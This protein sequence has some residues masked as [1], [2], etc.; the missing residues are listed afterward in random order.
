MQ[1]R[2]QPLLEILHERVR[3][4]ALTTLE[5]G[6]RNQVCLRLA[7]TLEAVPEPDLETLA[8]LFAAA[9][10]P[11]RAAPYAERAGDWASTALAFAQAVNLYMVALDGAGRDNRLRVLEK[12][13]DALAHAG[14]GRDAAFVYVEAARLRDDDQGSLLRERA[15]I[16]LLRAGHIEAG[17]DVLR[18]VA[19]ALGLALPPSP[20]RALA[21]LVWY[22]T[23]IKLRRQIMRARRSEA[24]VPPRQLRRIDLCWALG[25]GLV[26]VDLVRA[27]GYQSRHVLLASEAGEPYRISCALAKEAILS[28]LENQAGIV[29]AGALLAQAEVLAREVGHPHAL[30]WATTA[31]AVKAWAECRLAA[32]AELCEK[33]VALFNERCA[34]IFYE[35]GSVEVWFNLHV[36]F[37]LGRLETVARR[38]SNCVREAEARGDLYT[39]TTARAY[40]RPTLWL[41]QDSPEDARREAAEAIAQWGTTAWHHQHWAGL[42]ADCHVDLDEGAGARLLERVAAKLPNMKRTK[43]L[44]LRAPRIEVTYLEGRGALEAALATPDRRRELLARAERVAGALDGEASLWASAHASALRAGI[45]ALADDARKAS[46]PALFERARVSYEA[47]EMPLFAAACATS[48]AALVGGDE[49]ASLRATA[50]AR[51]E[52]AGVKHPDRFAAFLVPRPTVEAR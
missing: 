19:E 13:A 46:A 47:L 17:L 52:A 7:Q 4:A 9:G 25:N 18:P 23:R 42:R 27:A 43:Q 32:C 22:R 21:N 44:R 33:A 15:A 11:G 40:V 49:G 50:R 10:D 29:R 34:D 39:L 41:A 3:A 5:P 37:L 8:Q 36:Q 38:V 31:A 26:G 2:D 14:R 16:Q 30:A 20:R 12:L 6:E 48:R 45:A 1:V 51:M 28:A 35:V 24:E